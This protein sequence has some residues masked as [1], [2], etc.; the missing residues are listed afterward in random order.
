MT[1]LMPYFIINLAFGL[2]NINILRF[3]IVTQLGMLPGSTL[4]I[5]IGNELTSLIYTKELISIDLVI[6]LTAAGFLPI[7]IKK[8]LKNN[9]CELDIIQKLSIICGF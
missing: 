4:I 6:L 5:M 2:V 8:L 1:V 3:Y 7:I 9:K